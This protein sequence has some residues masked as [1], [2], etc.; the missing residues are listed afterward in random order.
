MARLF[1]ILSLV[2]FFISICVAVGGYVLISWSSHA[3][4]IGSEIVEF[5]LEKGVAL[6]ALAEGLREKNLISSSSKFTIW[7][8]YFSNFRNYQAGHYAF[9]RF[10][11]PQEIEKSFLSGKIYSVPKLEVI[12]PEGFTIKQIISRFVS[13]G[14]AS[15]DEF[16]RLSRDPEFLLSQGISAS[17]LE[18]Y[19]YPAKYTF[20]DTP[21]AR[22]VLVE[23]IKVFWKKLPPGYE[24]LVASRGITL[25][26]AMIIASL[27]EAETSKDFEKPMVAEVIWNRL[28]RKMALGIDAAVIY[29]IPQ[30]NGNLT[31]RD[32]DDRK[33]P[34]NLRIHLGLPP[35]PITTPSKES[36]LAVV[37]PTNYG[38]LFYVLNPEKQNEHT[39][40]KTLAEHNKAVRK[41]V[42][43]R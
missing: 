1:T 2:V 32:L 11:S 12:I 22:D 6:S 14:V 24:I 26:Q 29:G 3:H 27:V 34:Y 25:H 36:L 41:L 18:G 40:S 17:S 19:L 20:Y 5:D 15:E 30:F 7:V 42:S 43:G 37:N 28:E 8:K 16:Y 4:D 21:S 9:S 23:M 31:R 33:N 38:Y 35:T 13:E 39:F 10:V